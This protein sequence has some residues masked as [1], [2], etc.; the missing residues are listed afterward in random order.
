MNEY[1]NIYKE[2]TL[3]RYISNY[4]SNKVVEIE[5]LMEIK[6]LIQRQKVER[7]MKVHKKM[8]G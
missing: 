1:I 7:M 3:I 5:E 8:R 2:T 6:Q 4:L